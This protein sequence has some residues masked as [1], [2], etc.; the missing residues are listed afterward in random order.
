MPRGKSKS[1]RG[2]WPWF[3]KWGKVILAVQVTIAV[4]GLCVYAYK[5]VNPPINVA[6]RPEPTYSIGQAANVEKLEIPEAAEVVIIGDSYTLGTGA[7]DRPTGGW[8]PR[9]AAAEGW[10][11]TIR[12]IGGTGFTWGGGTDGTDGDQFINRVNELAADPAI[13]PDLVIIQGGQNDYRATP[14]ELEAATTETV[15]AAKAAWPEAEM[16]VFGPTAPKPLVDSLGRM[17]RPIGRGAVAAGAFYIDPITE[18]WIT[19][20]NSP[21]FDF[22]KAHVNDAGHEYLASRFEEAIDALTS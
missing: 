16:V 11:A 22:D 4:A 10:N 6:N 21:G 14:D 9:V 17:S 3:D 15:T 18:G 13:A 7:A 19:D 12:G 8:A 1:E 20:E 5:T 2:F